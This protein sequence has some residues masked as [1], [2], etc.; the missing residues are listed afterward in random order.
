MAAL[1]SVLAI[2]EGIGSSESPAQ[3]VA[4]TTRGGAPSASLTFA[5][6]ADTIVI[7][8]TH[9]APGR[10]R[11]AASVGRLATRGRVP[12]GYHKDPERSARTFVTIDGERW[13]LPGDMA[14]DRRRR[15]D[16]PAR[17]RRDVHQH[18]RREGVPRRGRGRAQDA[19]RRGR[20]GRARRARR[21]VRPAGGRRHLDH[22][23][24]ARNRISRSC[25]RTAARTSRATRCRARCTWSHE[26]PRTPAGKADY[27]WA[28]E[29][30]RR[31]TVQRFGR[32]SPRWTAAI[33][34]SVS[35]SGVQPC[36]LP[37]TKSKRPAA[38]LWHDAQS[39]PNWF[40]TF[41]VP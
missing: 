39:R 37:H 23:R 4:V 24:R 11:A 5:A 33:T 26:I 19:P 14:T 22:R 25:R 31:L 21:P 7:D 41:V 34:A 12:L 36:V 20:R 3:A 28:R 30:D 2:V 6:K 18:R 9:A 15:D 8:E 38:A 16:P 35:G 13:S 40:T 10:A 27:A 17:P 32:G 29:V 1:P